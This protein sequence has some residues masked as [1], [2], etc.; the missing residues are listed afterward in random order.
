MDSPSGTTSTAAITTHQ[1]SLTDNICAK[2]LTMMGHYIAFSLTFLIGKVGWLEKAKSA[3]AH[4]WH[5]ELGA[6]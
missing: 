3:G 1:A 2:K 5:L 4:Q 6:S